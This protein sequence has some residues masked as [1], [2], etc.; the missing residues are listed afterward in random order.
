MP[1]TTINTAQQ[2][3]IVQELLKKLKTNYVF[4]EIANNLAESIH[5]R[6]TSGDYAS[7]FD[8]ESFALALTAHLQEANQD[9]HLRVTWH[10]EP[11][12]NDE[13][14]EDQD[15]ASDAREHARLINYCFRKIERLPGNVG[16]MNLTGF[17]PPDWAADTL[18]AAMTFL[19]N[20]SAL[21]ID[22]RDCGGG[23]V[24]MVQVVCSYF[25]AKP[26][27]LNDFYWRPDDSTTQSWTMPCVPG[28][29]LPEIPLYILTSSDTFSAGEDFAYTLQAL[30][31]AT[32]VGQTT[33]GGAHPGGTHRL[34]P[35]MEVFI[36][37]GRAI[38]PITGT[39]W[40]GTGVLPDVSASREGVLNE[41][42]TR[43]LKDIRDGIDATSSNAHRSLAKEIS[44]ALAGLESKN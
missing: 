13:D 23:D 17:C 26:T 1:K 20:M 18:A 34:H 29:R 11:L 21:I 14:A 36:P 4:P 7:M 8:G 35:H 41:A 42:Y 43:A 39:N 6:L 5:E 38:N 9:K 40:E 10:A 2:A 31:R 32:I 24:T 44:S 28:E 16:I 19:A 27:H 25:F 3:E 12:G 15:D 33:R 30:K 37:S 22:L